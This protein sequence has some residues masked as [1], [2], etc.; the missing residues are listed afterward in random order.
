MILFAGKALY[1]KNELIV[2]SLFIMALIAYF[3]IMHCMIRAK[4]IKAH[5]PEAYIRSTLIARWTSYLTMILMLV[6]I[7]GTRL[8]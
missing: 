5:A 6:T 8:L 3:I 7:L 4:L 2:F 1:A